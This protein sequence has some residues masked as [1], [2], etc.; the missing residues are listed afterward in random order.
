M[1]ILK[2]ITSK[3]PLLHFTY[4]IDKVSHSKNEIWI[5]HQ[6]NEY[7]SKN[8]PDKEK[9]ETLKLLLN[10]VPKKILTTKDL[11]FL[12]SELTGFPAWIIERCEAETGNFIK[13]LALLLH[14]STDKLKLSISDWITDLSKTIPG[15]KNQI[16]K[17]IQKVSKCTLQEKIILLNLLTGTFKSP[18][19]KLLTLKV[20]ANQNQIPLE[21]AELRL[22]EMQSR[23]QIDYTK[24][25]N[26][27]KNENKKIPDSFP[28]IKLLDTKWGNKSMNPEAFAVYGK[29]EGIIAQL[30][31][32]DGSVYLWSVDG[33]ILNKKF[34][35]VI[36]HADLYS[37]N[38]KVMGQII[39][40]D[41]KTSIEAL[42]G[43]MSKKNI[44][45]KDLA[46][47]PANFEIWQYI[48]HKINPEE[49]NRMTGFH[50]L[51]KINFK[52]WDDFYAI[53]KDCRR[54]GY[55]GL[56]IQKKD[57]KN[58]YLY[59]KA[60]SFSTIA[61]LIYVVLDPMDKTGLKSL[62]FGLVNQNGDIVSIGS[63]EVYNKQ[64]DIA[65]IIQ[66]TRQNTIERFGPVRSVQPKLLFELYFEGISISNRRKSG[67]LLT[68]VVV[69][70]KIIE[71]GVQS[72]TIEQ[73]KKL[74]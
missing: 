7:F 68:N 40:Q 22:Y 31:K 43:R 56:L 62:T 51:E 23:A 9:T 64:V 13:A 48:D 52:T 16:H 47:S 14:T 50:S 69:N 53:H 24:L 67:L 10:A 34:P 35:E 3:I 58:Q 18:I 20:I 49:F 25:K 74:L 57:A 71:K 5:I 8:I 1:L 45:K 65:E 29:K 6:L 12:S 36:Q 72:D 41:H 46:A 30:V 32:Y 54:L 28:E 4:L 38:F 63:S 11:K 42:M 73:L 21:I 60:S 61:Q 39:P 17:L 27:V 2:K 70:K 55:T 26:A 66:F 15:N 44:S 19:P 59:K 33:L 37:G